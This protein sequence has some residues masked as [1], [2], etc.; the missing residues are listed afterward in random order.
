MEV[1]RA[2]RGHWAGL[3]RDRERESLAQKGHGLCSDL[4]F[5][6]RLSA[7]NYNLFFHNI[8]F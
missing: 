5:I 8:D 6:A 7:Y 2:T 1:E 4:V 3:V